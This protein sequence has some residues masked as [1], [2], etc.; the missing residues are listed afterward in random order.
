MNIF[1]VC[2][3]LDDTYMPMYRYS[4]LD[5][6]V[7]PDAENIRIFYSDYAAD[8]RT[9]DGVWRNLSVQILGLAENIALNETYK[10]RDK[11]GQQCYNPNL[12]KK[13]NLFKYMRQEMHDVFNGDFMKFLRNV[14]PWNPNTTNIHFNWNE[15]LNNAS[16]VMLIEQ[17]EVIEIDAFT[18]QRKVHDI[19][20]F[21]AK[22]ITKLLGKYKMLKATGQKPIV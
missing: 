2:N 17:F 4:A 12:Q 9:I 6:W 5:K 19:L 10:K 15:E 21:C 3:K 11:L 1:L 8:N 14:R 16:I 22:K 18:G 20:D 7:K 13:T